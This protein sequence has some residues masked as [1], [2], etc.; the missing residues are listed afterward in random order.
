MSKVASTRRAF[1][2]GNTL[3]ETGHYYP[4][5]VTDESVRNC[6]GCGGCAEVCPTKIITVRSRVPIVDFKVG[7][8]TFCGNCS[9]RCPERVFPPEPAASFTHH[10][11]ITGTCL[12]LN[13][14]DCQACRDACPTTAIRFK[15]RLGG[16]FV[17]VLDT[18][19]CTGCGACISVCPTQ[20]I[21]MTANTTE[22]AHA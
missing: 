7:E 13:F 3:R 10:A 12:A 20:S 19:P 16:P 18:D 17:P 15:P 2:T 6:S 22:V 4:P 21:T 1:L 14:V 9:K 8:C 11:V 5:G